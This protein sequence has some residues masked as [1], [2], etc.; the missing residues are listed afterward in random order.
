MRSLIF[1]L[2]LLCVICIPFAGALFC[3]RHGIPCA[4]YRRVRATIGAC[5]RICCDLIFRGSS[6]AIRGSRRHKYGAQYTSAGAGKDD[7]DSDIEDAEMSERGSSRGTSLL[8]FSDGY[9][10]DTFVGP[11]WDATTRINL[12]T[13]ASMSELRRQVCAMACD[14]FGPSALVEEDL[15]LECRFASWPRRAWPRE[16]G[17]VE[18]LQTIEAARRAHVIIAMRVITRGRGTP[19]APPPRSPPLPRPPP[20]SSLAFTS[21]SATAPVHSA[22]TPLMRLRP[23]ELVL[24]FGGGVEEA[25]VEMDRMQCTSLDVLRKFAARALEEHAHPRAG[26]SSHAPPPRRYSP[27]E[28]RLRCTRRL[29]GAHEELGSTSVIERVLSNLDLVDAVTLQQVLEARVVQVSVYH[30]G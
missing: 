18:A 27:A 2:L 13:V 19:P 15:Q 14:L 29:A 4:C 23:V 10:G 21:T 11:A 24:H 9:E 30:D 22:R 20:A 3:Y 17:P 16:L 7:A 28:V 5:Y 1:A 25:T 12:S 6:Q 26:S 8:L